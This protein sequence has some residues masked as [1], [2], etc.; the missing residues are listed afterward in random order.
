[1]GAA[2]STVNVT[3]HDGACGA[4][5]TGVHLGDLD[6]VAFGHVLEAWHAYGVVAF[7]GGAPADDEPLSAVAMETDTLRAIEHPTAALWL[8][9]GQYIGQ[10]IARVPLTGTGSR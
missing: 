2:A 6:E 5:V 1:M 9:C 10:I 8:G 7:P 3:P 4:T